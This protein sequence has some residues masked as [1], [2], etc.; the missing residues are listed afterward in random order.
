[1]RIQVASVPLAQLDGSVHASN[2]INDTLLVPTVV[3][4]IF[5]PYQEHDAGPT[6]GKVQGFPASMVPEDRIMLVSV[7]RDQLLLIKRISFWRDS[8][9][10]SEHEVDTGEEGE[11]HQL[12]SDTSQE[13]LAANISQLVV[14]CSGE[15]TACGLNEECADIRT[16]K[17]AH[18]LVGVDRFEMCMSV[19]VSRDASKEDVISYS[20]SHY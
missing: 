10:P 15:P 9:S 2:L 6:E 19:K 12:Q 18:D 1:M 4:M 11:A 16:D 14:L 17:D 5:A 13:D 8:H 7:E 3:F 20:D